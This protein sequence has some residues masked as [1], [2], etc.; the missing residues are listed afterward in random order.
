MP[1]PLYQASVGVK[2][3]GALEEVR[4]K[5]LTSAASPCSEVM[6]GDEVVEAGVPRRRL[7][8]TLS[9]DKKELLSPWST[10]SSATQSIEKS[11]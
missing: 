9:A 1:Y 2:S 5:P 10:Y 4:R 7:H 8:A 3:I 11:T 6:R